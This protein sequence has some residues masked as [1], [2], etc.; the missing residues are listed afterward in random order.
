MRRRVLPPTLVLIVVLSMIASFVVPV[1]AAPPHKDP[2]CR[3]R[4]S[5]GVSTA[6][7]LSSPPLLQAPL[8]PQANAPFEIPERATGLEGPLGPQDADAALQ[9]TYG[10]SLI[11]APSVSFDGPSNTSG[12]NPLTQLATSVRTTT[13]P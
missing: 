3:L 7:K 2:N 1:A 12:Y 11:P 10:P 13:W 8:V 9:T 5:I 6:V 4:A